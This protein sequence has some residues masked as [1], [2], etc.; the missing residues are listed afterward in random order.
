MVY[1]DDAGILWR[2]KPRHHMTADSLE[3]LHGFSQRIGIKRCWFHQG[4]HPH[5]DVTDVQRDQAI[6]A[7][8]HPVDQRTLV[9]LSNR[10]RNATRGIGAATPLVAPVKQPLDR[11]TE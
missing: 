4:R 11:G 8:A 10:L 9:S 1:V 3:E 5:Y 6:E 2:G 7:G